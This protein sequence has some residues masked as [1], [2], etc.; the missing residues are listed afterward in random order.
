MMIEEMLHTEVDF[1]DLVHTSLL[2]SEIAR[3]RENIASGKEWGCKTHEVRSRLHT[4]IHH[5][6]SV[7]ENLANIALERGEMAE[8]TDWKC[9][10]LE[11]AKRLHGANIPV[12]L[13]KGLIRFLYWAPSCVYVINQLIPN[14][15]YQASQ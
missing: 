11:L 14:T 9:K 1:P 15:M 7:L 2:M 12:L 10:E 4:D 8:F 5:R 3:K 6:G 13:Q